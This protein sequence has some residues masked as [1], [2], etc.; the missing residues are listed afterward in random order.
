VIGLGGASNETRQG[1][2]AV[3]DDPR[4][5]AGPFKSPTPQELADRYAV[6]QLVKIYALG[7]DLRDMDLVFSAFA[8]D[9]MAEG[10][11]SSGPVKE[12]LPSVA[13]GAAEFKGGTQH[14][15]TNQHVTLNGDEA[16]VWSYAIAI[17]KH[18]DE[19]PNLNMGVIYKDTCRRF[20]EG[21]LIV[22]RKVSVLWA[23]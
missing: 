18:L 16:L 1:E 6:S 9:A 22:H 11:A 3:S 14:N 7:V 23:Q 20:P 2:N 8:P 13:G 19:R 15:I 12:Y 10:S 4:Q 5:W 21:W 17:H